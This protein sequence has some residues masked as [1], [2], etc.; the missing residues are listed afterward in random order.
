MT[1]DNEIKSNSFLH[2]HG[3]NP[4]TRKNVGKSMQSM[5]NGTFLSKAKFRR[6]LPFIVFLMILGVLYISN[7]FRVERTKRQIDNLEEELRELRYE[8]ISSRSK[9]M[10]KSKPS[11][12][13]IKLEE[14]GIHESMVPPRK[15]MVTK[16]KQA[17]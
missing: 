16:E 11:E 14:T 12:I 7:M 15:I 13:A 10:Y 8:Y 6:A 1:T 9:L 3:K 2:L 17:K 4:I 5:L